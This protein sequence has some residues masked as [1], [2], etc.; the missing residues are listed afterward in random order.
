M[1]TPLNYVTHFCG[2]GGACWGLE[3]AGLKCSLAVDN[4][5]DGPCVETRAA[6]LKCDK[7]L[8]LDVRKYFDKGAD[9]EFL[10][11]KEE[12][13][14]DLFLLWTSPPCKKFS[15]AGKTTAKEKNIEMENLYK[16][17]VEFAAWA[18][19]KYVVVENV[20][21]LIKHE[22]KSRGF[23]VEGRLTEMLRAFRNLGYYAEWNVLNA[24]HFGVP[25]KRQRVFIVCSRDGQ[26]NL[27]PYPKIKRAFF[28][29]IKEHGRTDLAL[30]EGTYR[31]IIE[32]LMRL[33]R[34][35]VSYRVMLVGLKKDRGTKRDCLFTI[36]CGHGGGITRKKLAV[37][38]TAHGIDFLRHLSLKEGLA[39]QGF[40]TTW[41][42]PENATLAWNLIGNAVPSPVSRAIAEHLIKVDAGEHPAAME[43]FTDERLLNISQKLM[44]QVPQG[45]AFTEFEA[46]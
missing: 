19:P 25:Q 7:G 4:N 15:M 3:Q 26:R 38:D 10:Y 21:G 41:T 22:A 12:H 32:K 30:K 11:A 40:P 44:P 18:K 27:I 34:K 23:G 6:N 13:R 20:K 42:L 43:A 36:T 35:D 28:S 39:A 8:C 31:T 9:G 1:A 16:A 37:S 46:S 2:I 45:A 5:G 14:K 24:V 33:M 17:S 29:D